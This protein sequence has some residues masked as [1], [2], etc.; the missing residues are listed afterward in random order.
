MEKKLFTREEARAFLKDNKLV[1]AESIAHALAAHYKDLLQEALEAEMDQELG[2]SKYDWK[3]KETNNSRNG[4]SAKT[5]QCAVGKIDVKIPRDKEKKFNPVVIKKHERRINPSIDD[6]ILSMYAKGVSDRDINLHLK[7]IYHIDVSADMVSRITD[8]IL[9]IAKEWQNRPLQPMYPIVF[10]DGIVFSVRQDGRVIKKTTYII[11]AITIDGM[12][13][14]LGIWIGEHESSKFWMTVLTDLQQRGVKDILIS[15]IDGLN[16]FEEAIKA[17]FPDTEIQHCIVHQI[18]NSTKFVSWKDRKP[19]CADLKQV[20]SAPNEDKALA[21]LDNFE[22]KWGKKYAYAV[23]S[24]RKNWPT[25]ATFFNYP[26]EIRK[27]IYTTN[28]IEG[29]NRQ[30]R[31]VTKTKSS[32]P[33][34]D[35][36]LKLLYLIIMDQTKKWTLPRRDWSMVFNQLTIAF[37]DRVTNYIR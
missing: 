2:Y 5:V 24:W 12:K 34:D 1:D 29:F 26:D 35:S 25:L 37:G 7:E 17:V 8:K 16:G 10:L 13:D 9:P 36:L 19:F 33:T 4:H 28:A 30:I 6:R 15:S 31:K 14:I 27:I 20:Y 32:F 22:E 3:N 11:S 18:R 23:S 21:E